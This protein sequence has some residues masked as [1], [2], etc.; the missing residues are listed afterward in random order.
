[1]LGSIITV[2][3]TGLQER[4]RRRCELMVTVVQ[5]ADGAYRDLQSL[6]TQK[7]AKC[8]GAAVDK[9][10]YRLTGEK[11]K[12]ALVNYVLKV[13]VALVYGEGELL[14]SVNALQGELLL[15]TESI[16]AARPDTWHTVN[17][18]VLTAFKTKI[19]PLRTQLTREL[20]TRA[21]RWRPS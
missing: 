16:W 9:L 1:L 18:K 11:L 15:A 19:D 7:A 21:Q 3:Y 20:F 8:E 17:E 2:A 5:W 12:Q 14:R 6:H 10:A 4:Y 13:Q